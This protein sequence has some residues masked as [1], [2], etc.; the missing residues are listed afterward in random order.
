M[1]SF[2]PYAWPT[3]CYVSGH[4]YSYVLSFSLGAG[5]VPALLLPEIFASRIR[6]KAVA[7]SMG[8][9]WVSH[10]CYNVATIFSSLL[11]TSC[12]QFTQSLRSSLNKNF[13]H[14]YKTWINLLTYF[15]PCWNRYLTSSLGCTS[16]VLWLCMASVRCTWD[17]LLSVS[18]LSCT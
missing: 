11:P 8:M 6:A 14:T 9:H 16:W 18:L 12:V 7:L 3:K 17:L 5:P 15:V 2:W 1:L 4:L 10:Y 13:C